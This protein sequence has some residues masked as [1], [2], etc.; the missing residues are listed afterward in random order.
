LHAATATRTGAE[1][2]RVGI[3]ATRGPGM[4]TVAIYVG[5]TQIGTIS[6]SATT[7]HYRSLILLPP[8]TYRTGTVRIKVIS[9]GKPV[10]IDG[11]AVTRT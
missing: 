10:Q 3:V 1:L 6:L 9:A 8:I 5:T 2:D 7:I 4:G 11:I